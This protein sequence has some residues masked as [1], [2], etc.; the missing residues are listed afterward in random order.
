M[1]TPSQIP[2][3]IIITGASSGIGAAS[4]LAAALFWKGG[5]HLIL[6]ARRLDRLE[7]IAAKCREA[8]AHAIPVVS[9]VSRRADVDRLVASAREHFGRLDVML[10]NAGFGLLAKIH[11]TTEAQ[12]DEIFAT[13]V[14]GTLYCMQAAAEVMLKQ[15]PEAPANRGA[16]TSSP[17][18]RGREGARC[19]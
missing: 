7:A 16:G 14:K 13:N 15:E 9:D 3:V 5:A 11:Q 12:F 1:V 19:P 17:S 18:P 4:A 8:G 6:G 10:A 2:K